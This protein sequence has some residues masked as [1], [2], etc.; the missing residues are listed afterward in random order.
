MCD[1]NQDLSVIKMWVCPSL[2]IGGASIKLR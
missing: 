2:D 1:L